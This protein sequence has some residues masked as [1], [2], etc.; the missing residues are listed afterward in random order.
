MG[1]NQG[2]VGGPQSTVKGTP[3]YYATQH[4]LDLITPKSITSRNSEPDGPASTS[5]PT[6][7]ANTLGIIAAMVGVFFV[8][9]LKIP[10]GEVIFFLLLVGAIGFVAMK[11]KKV[12]IVVAFVGMLLCG[13]YGLFY[14]LSGG[15]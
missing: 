1:K 12:L 4:W 10:A 2:T 8:F 15:R 6:N 7:P 5:K 11:M 13:V 3:D 9:A 14:F